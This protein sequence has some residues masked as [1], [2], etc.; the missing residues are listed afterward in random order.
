MQRIIAFDGHDGCG[1]STL[2]GEVAR[3]IG[4]QVVKPYPDSLGDH[5][6]WLWGKGRFREADALARS[7]VERVLER[8]DPGRPIVFDR[9]WATMYTVLPEEMWPAWRPLPPTVICHADTDVIM[10]R[11]RQRGESPG[12]RQEHEHY[13]RF[14]VS[15]A[16]LTPESLLLDTSLASVVDSTG[17]VLRF[18]D[19]LGQGTS[20][21]SSD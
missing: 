6:A 17:Q 16:K 8:A 18:L 3:H 10:D 4:G 1:K 13:G 20:L 14:Y 19:G 12:E 21:P 5:I 7:S 11:L 9:H 15:L 2:A